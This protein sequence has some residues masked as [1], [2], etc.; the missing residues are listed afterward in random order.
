MN[1]PLILSSMAN[2]SALE[3]RAFTQRLENET[4]DLLII[5]GGIT[6]AGIAL[7]AISRG[8]TVALVEKQD[9]GAGTSSRSTKLIHGGLR[10]LKQ[11][12]F[13]IVREVGQERAI[14]YKN[15]PH[16]VIPEKMLLPIIKGGSLG[17][18]STS[19]GL[20][21]YDL[22]AGVKRSERRYMLNKEETLQK[23]PL[24]KEDILLGGGMYIE[25]RSDDARLVIE[26][27]KTAFNKGAMCLNYASCEQLTYNQDGKVNGAII[28]DNIHDRTFE[29]KAKSI[30]NA[31]GPWVDTIRTLD[32]SLK[33][34]RLHLTKGI[35]V[36]VPKKRLPI[37]QSVYFD[38]PKDGRMMF[39]IPRGEVVYLGT[40]DTT[41]SES[42]NKPFADINDVEYV[43]SAANFMFPNVQL[44]RKDVLSSW[45]G[46]RPLIHEDGKSPSDLSRKDEI[47]ISDSGLISIAGGKL[48][49]FRKMAQRSVDVVC[50]NLHHEGRKFNKCSTH[51]IPLSGGEGID[52]EKG[53]LKLIEDL[54][55]RFNSISKDNIKDLVGKFGSNTE[56]IL[57]EAVEKYIDQPNNLLIAEA[58]YCINHEMVNNIGDFLVRRTGRL[59]FERP[60]IESDRQQLSDFF[61]QTLSYSDEL[62]QKFSNEFIEEYKGVMN[63]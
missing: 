4:F 60:S 15:A 46:L 31:C 6:G 24:L 20:F 50:K 13:G 38:I 34:K 61:Q 44:E 51:N 43:L 56:I 59:Y 33:G 47:F 45:A 42:I 26:V 11:L 49:G 57:K 25:Y 23:E 17:K 28:K 29:V 22:L 9:F 52:G 12:E 7:D 63:F 18:K 27:M 54:S 48:T 14:L 19:L 62:S 53:V 30:I 1:E 3:R 10:Y 40:T 5:G 55:V 8:L 36:V 58:N 35:H 32:K 41:Y 21:V 37:H 39:A 2:F 16:V